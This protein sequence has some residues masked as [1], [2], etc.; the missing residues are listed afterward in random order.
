MTKVVITIRDGKIT[1]IDQRG[2]S[3]PKEQ[4]EKLLI[5]INNAF[6]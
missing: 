6:D 3:L 2:D 5:G 1:W 4:W